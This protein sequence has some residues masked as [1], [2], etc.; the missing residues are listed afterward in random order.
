[1]MKSIL[2]N[3]SFFEIKTYIKR[4]PKRHIVLVILLVSYYFCLPKPLFNNPTATVIESDTGKL[5]GAKIAS[6][7][8]W[9]FP[10]TNR[11]SYKFESCILHFEDQY[12]YTH[13]GFNPVAI[14]KAI[15]TNFKAG[16]VI[17]GGSTL[18]QQVIR[19]ARKGKKRTY[20]E[21][22]I[23][24]IMATRLELGYSKKD[25]LNLYASQA[26]FGGNVVG[27]DMAAWRY[28]GIPAN[29]LSWAENATLAVLPNAPSLIYPGKHNE[30][31]LQKRNLLLQKLLYNNVIDS[32]TYKLSIQENL[33][34]KPYPLPQLA[35]HLLDRLSNTHTGKR[36]I[37]N[38]DFKLQQ[39]VN[40]IV[41][42]KHS[43]YQQNDIHNIAVMVMD[44]RSR[45]VKSY[46]G[47]TP[48][49][50]YHQKDV[51][52]IMAGRSTGSVLK[53]L[54]YAAMMDKGEL[55]PQQLVPDIPTVIA[56]YA[57][58]NFNESY[59]GA[60]PANKALARSLNI[61]AVRLLQDYGIQR[62][63]DEL[64]A[65]NIKNITHNANHYGLSLI[66]GGAEANLWDLCKTYAGLGSTVNHYTETSSQYYT[67]EFTEEPRL[68]ANNPV[69]FK[70]TTFEKPIYSAGSIWATL[71]AMKEVNRP[72]GDEAW[73]FYD[74]AREVAWK[75]GTSFGNRDAWAIGLNTNYV[76]GVWVGNADGEGRP[77]LTGLNYAAPVLFD[78]FTL[79][80]NSSWFDTPYD[81][82]RK[83]TTCSKS[84]FLASTIC[85]KTTASIVPALSTKVESC[86]FHQVIH[87]D[88][89]E[90]Y[91]VD[92]SC[93]DT[94]QM[95]H[96]PWF[97]L[98]T[99]QAHYYKNYHSNYKIPPA[100]HH[101]C[102]NETINPLA[103]I[104]PKENSDVYLP[105]GF[106]GNTNELILKIAHSIP[107]TKIHWYIN[108][109]YITT[110][111]QFHEI[112]IHPKPG[113][114][115]ITVIDEHGNNLTRNITIKKEDK[116]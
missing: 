42:Q 107:K 98:P 11:I 93:W 25:I 89:N 99:L 96:K 15:I 110:T 24:L 58:K 17:R 92:A 3:V 38:I 97:I 77:K 18:T 115:I 103:F 114:H 111:Q 43:S 78:V 20:T 36:L 64:N 116:L 19:L 28:F 46:V 57:P 101:S 88:T 94:N 105:K 61:P 26:P 29:Q 41:K 85:P 90:A 33:P 81:D 51:D 73:E 100:F 112:P 8:Q 14:L 87:L 12:F 76:V 65:M 10:A 52:I 13:P 35:P 62:F 67:N 21:K 54:L 60:V 75:T 40:A 82:L 23:E 63:I 95:I 80:P 91:Q 79:L 53:P 4:H 50:K 66:L 84:G 5:L 27:I 71:E 48:T 69:H 16:K 31:L 2:N 56:G 49:D 113:K 109:I 55:L 68:I 104:F 108:N 39:Q 72:E 83:V 34:Q 70:K 102:S 6:N 74:S 30:R 45:E 47:N 32:L 37:T 22:F 59:S 1:M 106:S 86:K 9:H 44:I 7:G